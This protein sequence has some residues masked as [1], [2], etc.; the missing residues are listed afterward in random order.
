MIY[1]FLPILTS[2]KN[3]YGVNYEIKKNMVVIEN[4]IGYEYKWNN[5]TIEQNWHK[6]LS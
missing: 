5:F 3:S 1:F 2:S 6:K 4:S